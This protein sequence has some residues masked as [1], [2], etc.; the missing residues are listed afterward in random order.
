MLADPPPLPPRAGTTVPCCCLLSLPPFPPS[1]SVPPKFACRESPRAWTVSHMMPHG[2]SP[3]VRQRS[4]QQAPWLA[5][6]GVRAGCLVVSLGTCKVEGGLGEKE[7]HPM[8]SATQLDG[9]VSSSPRPLRRELFSQ[10]GDRR[11][12]VVTD[13]TPPSPEPS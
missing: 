3:A 2:E 9:A 4:G 10:P 7:P 12:D 5:S 1:P 13:E 8:P 11:L 6:W